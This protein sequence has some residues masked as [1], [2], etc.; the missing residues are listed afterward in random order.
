MLFTLRR[1]RLEHA[2]L[3]TDLVEAHRHG[4]LVLFAGA[5]V[6]LPPP[7]S[8]PLLGDLAHRV[9]AELGLADD[10]SRTPE[11]MFEELDHAH[12]D[13]PGLVC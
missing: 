7:S 4:R 8:I 10:D 3:P 13:H 1:V 12:G 11:E 5:G 9:A 6:S 2:E